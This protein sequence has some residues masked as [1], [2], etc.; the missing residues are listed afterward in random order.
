MSRG[1]DDRL[2]RSPL[3]RCARHDHKLHS[4]SS[5]DQLIIMTTEVDDL[6]DASGSQTA[7][8]ESYNLASAL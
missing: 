2:S 8:G 1:F 4:Q 7:D 6:L 3:A 5:L